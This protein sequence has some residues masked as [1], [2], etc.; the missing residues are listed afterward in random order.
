MLV[1]QRNS[2]AAMM[3]VIIKSCA[4]GVSESSNRQD[5]VL[6]DQKL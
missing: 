4:E 6:Q 2:V 3:V 1:K 5:C